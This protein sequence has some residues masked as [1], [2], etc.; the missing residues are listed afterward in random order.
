MRMSLAFAL[1]AAWVAAVVVLSLISNLSAQ[2]IAPRPSGN[3]QVETSTNC[4]QGTT[5]LACFDIKNVV[6]RVLFC[7]NTG[8]YYIFF[9][10]RLGQLGDYCRS[11]SELAEALTQA[12]A[13]QTSLNESP[14][15]I[16]SFISDL[17]SI[18]AKGRDVFCK[19][20]EVARD[21][22]VANATTITQILKD[23]RLRSARAPIG[24][25]GG[26]YCDTVA[27]V[28]I[29]VTNSLVFDHSIFFGDLSIWYMTAAA[30]L[31]L[32]FVSSTG[33]L[34]IYRS[35]F[36][37]G[38][39]A[40][41]A[42][43]AS[44]KVIQSSVGLNLVAS[45]ALFA[46]RIE[47]AQAKIG[48]FLSVD[49]TIANRLNVVDSD[50]GADLNLRGSVVLRTTRIER[51]KVSGPFELQ[52]ASLSNTLIKNNKIG[53]DVE[54]L[55]TEFRCGVDL[56]SNSISGGL[57]WSKS[58]LRR[59]VVT[60]PGT[61]TVESAWSAAR[62]S[63]ARKTFDD[64]FALGNTGDDQAQSAPKVIP[65]PFETLTDAISSIDCNAE[66]LAAAPAARFS[67]NRIEKNLCFESFR[68]P[69]QAPGQLS[70]TGTVVSGTTFLSLGPARGTRA[71]PAQQGP[72][73]QRILDLV[74]FQTGALAVAFHEDAGSSLRVF[75]TG[76]RFDRVFDSDVHCQDVS[77]GAGFGSSVTPRMGLPRLADLQRWL[78][79]ADTT[80]AHAA[81]ITAF[82]NAG[83]DTTDLKIQKAR[84][85]WVADFRAKQAEVV[86]AWHNGFGRWL[87]TQAPGRIWDYLRLAATRVLGWV[88]DFG[89]RPQKA[90]LYVAIIAV[91]FTVWI[92]LLLKVRSA[93]TEEQHR[94]VPVGF[95]FVI[96]YMIPGFRI[97]EA[98]F[99]VSEF[100]FADGTAI[101]DRTKQL[102]V[103]T[104]RWI[105]IVGVIAAVFIAAALKTL[106]VD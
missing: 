57:V 97:D 46:D 4:K 43:A 90:I 49:K 38:I 75:T 21:Q 14:Q 30:N 95:V 58:R 83:A 9:E 69:P 88:A 33:E 42:I 36:A 2:T 54:L 65:S 37:A 96:D 47:I 16:K 89:Y 7:T 32:N 34:G 86:Q 48:G 28:G 52:G 15:R 51:T 82:N 74:G 41:N 102:L 23:G 91:L 100:R 85:E 68:S 87:R 12:Y 20:P 92:S 53:I 27:L 98:H 3:P 45:E 106:A 17:D 71:N 64:F 11:N 103:M 101:D 31:S 104:L 56:S 99:K 84:T 73:A 26:I 77:S 67:D 76:L 63:S 72:N 35:Q 1:R 44:L 29:D 8:R 5:D 80:H 66:P 10:E 55:Q 81:A 24:L 93:L 59:H 50:V 18:F 60:R 13:G 6:D 105:K 22:R 19:A 61:S 79:A 25:I 78:D 62:V 70:F 94:V 40:Q 39:Y